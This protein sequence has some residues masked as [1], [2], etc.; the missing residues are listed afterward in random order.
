MVSRE[1]YGKTIAKNLRRIMLEHEKTQ[2]DLAR[3]L[4][5]SKATLSSWMNG[6]RTPKMDKID[7]LCKYF[8]VSR[9][10]IMEEDAHRKTLRISKERAEL[11]QLAMSADEKNVCIVLDVLKRLEG[12]E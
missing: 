11:V 3:E 5:I 6:T 4:D 2:A 10:A 9:S 7:M 12:I 1:E 8:N